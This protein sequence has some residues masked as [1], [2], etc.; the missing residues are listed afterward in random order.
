[1]RTELTLA[2]LLVVALAAPAALPCGTPFG[3]GINVDPRQDIVVVH[4]NGAET[5]VFQ[6]RFC[7]TAQE[8]GLI[9]PVPAKLSAQPTL[10][11]A[12]VFS[13]LDEVS[14]PTVVYTT[15]CNSRNTGAG[16]GGGGSTGGSAIDASVA[17]VVSSGTVGFMDYAQLEATSVDALT[18]WLDTNGYPY[19]SLAKAAFESY[20]TKGWLF[21]AFRVNQGAV[22]NGSTICK[23][24][25]PIKLT[26]PTAEP[27]VP[28][29]MATARARDTTGMLSYGGGFSWRVFGIT[30][31]NDQIGFGNGTSS[32]RTLNFSG[33]LT[34]ADVAQLDGLAVAGDRAVKLNLTFNYGSTE[35]DVV[36]AKGAAKDY[37][38]VITQ[39][40]YVQCYDGGL[41]G[42]LIDSG[43]VQIGDASVESIPDGGSTDRVVDSMNSDTTVLINPP[44]S[45]EKGDAGVVVGADASAPAP[46]DAHPV[47]HAD[48]GQ[49]STETFNKGHSGCSFAGATAGGGLATSFVAA[50]VVGL[51]LRRRR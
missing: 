1:M 25:G 15:V 6:P 37:R 4:K 45:P 30:A 36:L 19:D 33:L 17:T 2:T 8:F 11:K 21:V 20:V 27:V 16:G 51:L 35:P 38:E 48:G 13:Q 46:A 41:D 18:T 10:S 32:S 26:F 49:T 29:R 44:E 34:A 3:N 5:Y 9:L 12:G 28:T 22:P 40:S 39:V 14:K 24:L 31:G 23:D 50:L 47:A 43:P 7:G 42:S